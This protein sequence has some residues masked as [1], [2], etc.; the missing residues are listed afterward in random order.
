MR[1]GLGFVQ[2]THTKGADIEALLQRLSDVNDSMTSILSGSSD[3]RLHTL[4]RHRDLLHDYNQVTAGQGLLLPFLLGLCHL[5]HQSQKCRR[6][7]CQSAVILSLPMAQEFRR[8]SSSMT[9]AR[10]RAELFSGAGGGAAPITVRTYAVATPVGLRCKT[11]LIA[12][13]A[14][15][16]RSCVAAV[17]GKD[18][19]GRLQ[20]G[21]AFRRDRSP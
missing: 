14:A 21:G 13:S 19:T 9:A 17:A 10:D 6:R 7:G 1:H 2:T 12:I 18:G 11:A 15:G 4:G 20:C 3:V 5:V 16:R 8:L